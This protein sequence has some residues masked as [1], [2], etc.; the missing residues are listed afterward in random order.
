VKL[1]RKSS[2]AKEGEVRLYGI[3]LLQKT[4]EG[5]CS[6]D[7]DFLRLGDL[8]NKEIIN[9]SFQKLQLA[10]RSRGVAKVV[11]VSHVEVALALDLSLERE[12]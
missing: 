6:E 12:R 8:L 2:F 10:R 4:S 11:I 5:V 9:L 7:S 1:R 3:A